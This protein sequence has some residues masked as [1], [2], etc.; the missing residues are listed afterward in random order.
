MDRSANARTERGASPR[1]MTAAGSSGG[2]CGMSGTLIQPPK[3]DG[4]IG[5]QGL[6]PS[7]DHPR[8]KGNTYLTAGKQQ[9]PGDHR[10]RQASTARAALFGRGRR[11]DTREM[12]IRLSIS[13]RGLLSVRHSPPTRDGKWEEGS[14]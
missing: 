5:S 10:Q 12:K 7:P 6:P 3:H 14:P 4:R 9:Q 2:R 13:K 11:L 1:T 8:E